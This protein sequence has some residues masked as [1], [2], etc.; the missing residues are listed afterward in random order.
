MNA[1]KDWMVGVTVL[2]AAL[3]V[4]AG[5][6][7]LNQSDLGGGK[8]LYVARFRSVGGLNA[9]AAVTVRGVKVGRVLAIRL[10]A[11]EWVEADLAIDREAQLPTSPIVIASSAS[12]FGEWVANI[13][14]RDP[15]PED[16]TTRKEILEAERPAGDAWPGA[17]LPDIGQ[18]T[19]QANRIA[20][21]VANVTKSFT[22]VLDSGAVRDLRQ[23]VL[24][25]SAISR[26]LVSFADAQ[27]VRITTVSADV[28]SATQDLAEAAKGFQNTIARI[29]S[30][31]QGDVV[32]EVTNNVRGSAADI[33]QAAADLRA[34]MVTARANEGSVVRVVTT[35]DSLLQKVN[36]GEGTLGMLATDSTL[37]KETTATMKQLRELMANIQADPKRYFKIS[38]F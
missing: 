8:E 9:G 24:D 11:N 14:P 16:P 31:T 15:L 7:W 26:R 3:V 4:V 17:T 36:R 19:Q 38:V 37:Y 22:T 25:L 10:A 5:A 33:R 21:D 27:S 12:L 20:N 29:D 1:R 30:A 28:S 13:A 23:S 18:L 6:L 32:P 2:V 35:A 34:L